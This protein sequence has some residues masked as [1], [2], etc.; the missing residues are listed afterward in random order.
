MNIRVIGDSRAEISGYV[1][2]VERNSKVLRDRYGDTFVERIC[3]GAFKRALDRAENVNLMLNHKKVL[4]STKE[5][6]LSLYE[7]AIGLHAR[8]VVTDPETV[9]QAKRGDL[10]GWSFGFYDMPDGVIK[11]EEKGIR[12]REVKDLDLKEVTLV[13]R[14]KVPAYDGTLVNVRTADDELLNVSDLT[15]TEAK[16][17][18]EEAPEEVRTEEPVKEEDNKPSA[19]D[20][21]KYH[22]IIKQM[23]G[24]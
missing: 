10:V 5:G 21:T 12:L 14:E 24:E 6:T 11:S 13:N 17:E 1:N 18:V 16:V 15:I 8:A 2:A 19:A 4:A 22:E 7:D 3:K 23:K 9:S 20:Y